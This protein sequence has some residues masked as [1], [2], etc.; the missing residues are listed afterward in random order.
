VTAARS[1]WGWHRLDA[2]WARRLVVESGVG[3]GDLVLDIGAGTGTITHELVRA[4]ARVVAFELHPQRASMLRE[5]FALDPVVVVRADATDMRLPTRPFGVVA[6]PPFGAITAILRRLVA[7][8][9][10]LT[11]AH[12]VVPLYVAERWAGGSAPGQG[13]WKHAFDVRIAGAVPVDAF[14]P[15]IS[16]TAAVLT[17]R[18]IRSARSTACR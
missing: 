18:S 10:R 9:S 6:N 12:V 3:P 2:R 11:H 7:R 14:R 5:R 13:A 4:G 1:R 17:I 8:G 15:P 16:R